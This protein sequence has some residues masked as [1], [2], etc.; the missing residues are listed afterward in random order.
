MIGAPVLAS[1]VMGGIT[2]FVYKGLIYVTHSNLISSCIAILFAIIIY[3]LIMI[4]TRGIT[5]EEL[6]MFPKGDKLV[7]LLDRLHLL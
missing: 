2:F 6:Y 3:A 4:L 7:H 1:A 5:E